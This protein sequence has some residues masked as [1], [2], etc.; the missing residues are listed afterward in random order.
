MSSN[1]SPFITVKMT[2][3]VEDRQHHRARR[4][5]SSRGSAAPFNHKHPVPGAD[6]AAIPTMGSKLRVAGVV[7]RRSH[8][9][10][11]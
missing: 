1:V 2:I 9:A 7:S 11:P 3:T 10:D 6:A 4:G 5:A 8:C